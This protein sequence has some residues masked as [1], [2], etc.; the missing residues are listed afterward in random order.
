MD[1]SEFARMKEVVGFRQRKQNVE[2]LGGKRKHGESFKRKHG[3]SFIN[4]YTI[5]IS[6]L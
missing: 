2:R 3:E 4:M 1:E 6:S 5:I